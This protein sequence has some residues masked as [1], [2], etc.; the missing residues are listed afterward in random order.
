MSSG[1]SWSFGGGRQG[2][3]RQADDGFTC[4]HIGTGKTFNLLC[5]KVLSATARVSSCRQRE[6]RAFVRAKARFAGDCRQ[7]RRRTAAGPH[8]IAS[9]NLF[10][11]YNSSRKR[12]QVPFL[13]LFHTSQATYAATL[14]PASRGMVPDEADDP[15]ES[16]G[17]A[18]ISVF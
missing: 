8:S 4:P 3:D 9:D 7:R 14:S 2:A 12:T 16:C 18:K 10:A 15:E 5:T 11:H 1:I 13:L 6:H 17:Y